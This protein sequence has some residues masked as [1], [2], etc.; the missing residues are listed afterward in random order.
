MVVGH[1]DNQGSSKDNLKLGERRAEFVRSY[2]AQNGISADQIEVSS[3]G[4]KD[5]LK[6]NK[7]PEGRAKNRRVEVVV[8]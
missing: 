4:H 3:R 5:P 1:T 7:T 2:L 6:S 8:K